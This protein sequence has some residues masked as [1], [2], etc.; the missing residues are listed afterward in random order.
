MSKPIG[1]CGTQQRRSVG[2]CETCSTCRSR[3]PSFG[4]LVRPSR[5]GDGS[6]SIASKAA[7]QAVLEEYFHVL[8]ESLG[9]SGATPA[10][11][12]EGVA[13]AVRGALGIRPAA[14]GVDEF[15]IDGEQPGLHMVTNRRLRSRFAM[16]FA[17]ARPENPGT[18]GASGEGEVTR[19]EKV[20]DAFNSPFWPFVL[21]ST[22][23]GQEGLDFH[24]T[25]T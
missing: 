19:M 11:V 3:S 17:D 18:T 22:S 20:R 9:L 16:P 2:P 4:V 12:I 23:V 1:H 25:V 10:K 8:V 24:R 5:T 21:V 6:C 15:R 14:V 7:Y 13:E